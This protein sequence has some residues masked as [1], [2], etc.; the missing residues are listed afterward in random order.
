MAVMLFRSMEEYQEFED[1][2]PKV[3]GARSV[4]TQVVMSPYKGVVWSGA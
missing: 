2:H 3:A 4:T 1:R